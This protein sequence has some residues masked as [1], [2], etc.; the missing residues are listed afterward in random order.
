LIPGS[1]KYKPF[2]AIS[3]RIK[4]KYEID[5]LIKE[6]PVE[7]NVF[8][9]IYFEEENFMDL[10]FRERR[11]KL[12]KIIKVKD[13]VIRPAKQIITDSLDEAN[14]FYE[15]A[16][17]IGEE[18]IMI[19]SLDAKYRQGRR[20]G[21]IVKMKPLVN[22]LDLVIVGAEYGS[23][24]RAGWLTSYFVACRDEDGNYLGVGKVSSGLKELE[25][26]AGTTYEEMSRILKPLIID[27]DGKIVRVRPEIVVAVTYQNIQKSPSYSSGYALRFP[28]VTA[29]RPDKDVSEINT[30]SDMQ[31]EVRKSER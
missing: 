15:E 31:R 14:S 13:K 10:T 27:E 30:L 23:G 3:Q 24:K 25:Q 22:D 11:K 29:Y 18:G 19:K 16:L 28:R 2:E 6:L 5:K 8:D 7:I 9:L 21:Y 20:V 17:K 26:E 4:R 1:G 12:E